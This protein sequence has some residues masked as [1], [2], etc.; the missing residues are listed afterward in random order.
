M[1]DL[2][3][4]LELFVVALWLLTKHLLFINKHYLKVSGDGYINPKLNN[5]L[6]LQYMY[7]YII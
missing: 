6:I 3:Y 2:N 7:V 4:L 1:L 5:L